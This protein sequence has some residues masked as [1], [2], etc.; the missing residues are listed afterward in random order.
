MGHRASGTQKKKRCT[1]ISASSFIGGLQMRVTDSLSWVPDCLLLAVTGHGVD[2]LTAIHEI[3][4][5]VWISYQ[6]RHDHKELGC[7]ERDPPRSWLLLG[8]GCSSAVGLA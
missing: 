1:L 5:G 8:A 4:I 7:T 3:H 2:D 6:V